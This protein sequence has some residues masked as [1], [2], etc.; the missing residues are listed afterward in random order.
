[1]FELNRTM[2]EEKIEEMGDNHLA[3]SAENPLRADAFD[4]SDDEKNRKNSRK[5]KRYFRDFRN[6]FNR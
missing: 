6:G 1:M 2:N 3:T 5:R 4:I